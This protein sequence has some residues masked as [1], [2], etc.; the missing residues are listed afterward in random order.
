MKFR[1]E[2][3]VYIEKYLNAMVNPD[4]P[5]GILGILHGATNIWKI[6]ATIVNPSFHARNIIGGMFQNHLADVPQRKIQAAVASMTTG[7]GNIGKAMRGKGTIRV[8]REMAESLRGKGIKIQP[9]G[10]ISAKQLR[11]EL[12]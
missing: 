3:A 10:E 12:Q 2:D 5:D 1:P 7:V 9:S 4:K 8:S 11:Q 6:L